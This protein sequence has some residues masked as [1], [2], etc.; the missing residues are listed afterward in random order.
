MVKDKQEKENELLKEVPQIN[1][2]SIQILMK[3]H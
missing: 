1:Q 2:K 3:D